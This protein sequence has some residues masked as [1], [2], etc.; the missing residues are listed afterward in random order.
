MS[1]DK[2]ASNFLWVTKITLLPIVPFCNWGRSSGS[3]SNL[4]RQKKS[5][6]DSVV[7][8]RFHCELF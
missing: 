1:L 2:V 4:I 3:K 7:I 6:Y 8:K 5:I